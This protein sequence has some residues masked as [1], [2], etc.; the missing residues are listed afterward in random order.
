MRDPGHPAAEPDQLALI[1]LFVRVR[2]DAEA[3]EVPLLCY[4]LK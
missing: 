3:V 2:S 4:R 1:I